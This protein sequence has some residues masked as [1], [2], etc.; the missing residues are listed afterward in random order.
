MLLRT[1]KSCG[2]DAPTLASSLRSRVGPIGLRQDI[3][4]GDG[5]KRARSP[6]SAK[7]TV[8]TIACGECRVIP[9]YSLLLVCVLPLPS[10]HEAAG[11]TGIWRSPRP[12]WAEDSSTARAHGAARESRCVWNSTSLRAQRS[13]PFLLW[14]D[15]LLRFARNDVMMR[16]PRHTLSRHRPRRRAIQYSETSVIESKGRSVLDTPLSRSMTAS[17]RR[18]FVRRNERRKRRSNLRFPRGSMDCFAG[19]R[20]DDQ[21]LRLFDNRIGFD[22]LP[23]AQDW[24]NPMRNA[25]QW[26]PRTWIGDERSFISTKLPPPMS[27]RYVCSRNGLVFAATLRTARSLNSRLLRQFALFQTGSLPCGSR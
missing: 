4:A 14:R 3:S 26:R 20:N 7:E 16:S 27:R 13:N 15:G 1:A 17:A 22:E 23:S 25:P 12:L 6:G 21:V 18:G 2:P 19:A 8:K 10:A 24:R 9:V 5:G 11:A